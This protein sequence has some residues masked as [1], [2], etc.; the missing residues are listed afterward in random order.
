[1]LL[2][3]CESNKKRKEIVP[4]S[5]QWK[6]IKKKKGSGPS[7][8]RRLHWPKFWCLFRAWA[9]GRLALGGARTYAEVFLG[10][11]PLEQVVAWKLIPWHAL[12]ETLELL[13]GE[14]RVAG[15][16]GSLSACTAPSLFPP[17]G[18]L[19]VTPA[20]TQGKSLTPATFVIGTL[21]NSQT[22]RGTSGDT[23]L[24]SDQNALVW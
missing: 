23:F 4:N 22:I 2:I 5:R 17:A 11:L 14:G 16:S 10:A 1:M 15:A 21:M 9:G 12:T 20:P 13:M 6:R 7:H 18:G 3:L 8:T 19:T 24:T